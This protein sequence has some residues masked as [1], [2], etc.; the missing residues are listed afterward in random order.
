MTSI[1]CSM[2]HILNKNTFYYSYSC[3]PPIIV[4][5]PGLIN[6][7]NHYQWV[8]KVWLTVLPAISQSWSLCRSHPMI[9]MMTRPCTTS[10]TSQK[11]M[12]LDELLNA[13]MRSLI[14]SPVIQTACHH[15]VIPACHLLSHLH[16]IPHLHLHLTLPL[17]SESTVARALRGS[18]HVTSRKKASWSPYL[19]RSTTKWQIFKL[20]T[21][22]WMGEH[23]MSSRVDS[24]EMSGWTDCLTILGVGLTTTTPRRCPWSPRSWTYWAS[25]R[26]FLIIASL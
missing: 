3:W 23:S 20:F 9:M 11:T 12:H 5:N 19:W 10:I 17:S 26:G 1:P 22:S 21:S 25:S 15:Q 16:L 2:L 4:D 24:Q 8:T 6:P 18:L 14:V 13:S 7:G